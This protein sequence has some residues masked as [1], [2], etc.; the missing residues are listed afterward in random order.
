MGS[1]HTRWTVGAIVALAAILSV[2]A[3]DTSRF[4]QLST[5]LSTLALAGTIIFFVHSMSKFAGTQKSAGSLSSL[6][7]RS[8]ASL[9]ALLAS[10]VAVVLA[11]SAFDGFA[12]IA[13]LV[14]ATICATSLITVPKLE[15]SAASINQTNKNLSP[16]L[17]WQAQLS[18][19][20]AL[21]SQT[22]NSPELAKL[23]EKAR[24]LASS[25]PGPKLSQE[26]DLNAEI[27]LLE[28]YLST[29]NQELTEKSISKIEGLFASRELQLKIQ[30][31]QAH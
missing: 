10:L 30:R 24:Y 28:A 16:Q 18:H 14:S 25:L 9:L 8:Q 17:M 22:S 1:I 7:L 23:A 31:S 19:L 5:I 20:S 2:Y 6:G 15:Q 3:Y 13:V 27:G 29:G 4:S 26:E 21:Y 11:E 12:F